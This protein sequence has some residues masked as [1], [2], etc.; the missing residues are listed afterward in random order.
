MVGVELWRAQFMSF[1]FIVGFGGAPCNGTS[2]EGK[3]NFGIYIYI[4]I[5]IK[6]D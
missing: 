3:N 2:Y 1:L 6:K 5:Y 4:Y